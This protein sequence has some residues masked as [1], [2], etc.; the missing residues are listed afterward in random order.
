MP[1]QKERWDKVPIEKPLISDNCAGEEGATDRCHQ[2]LSAQTCAE[3]P[4]HLRMLRRYVSQRCPHELMHAPKNRMSYLVKRW[5]RA[6]AGG[7]VRCQ[8]N[9][10]QFRENQTN[11]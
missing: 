10:G 3:M 11:L 7:F 1:R 6:D 2:D 9:L 8:A 4:R 5:S